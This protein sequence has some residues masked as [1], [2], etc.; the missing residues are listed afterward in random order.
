[1]MKLRT[2]IRL[3]EEGRRRMALLMLLSR[4]LDTRQPAQTTFDELLDLR[5]KFSLLQPKVIDG[6]DSE[7]GP[8]GSPGAN[9]VHEGAA[10]GAEMLVRKISI[11]RYP[12]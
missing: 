8:V 11:F 4:P 1:M 10:C 5:S 2:L 7:D 9:A 12:K 3:D 6:S